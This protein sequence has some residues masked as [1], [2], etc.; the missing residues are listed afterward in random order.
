MM[1]DIL[2][3]GVGWIASG[4]VAFIVYWI[5]GGQQ[6]ICSCPLIPANATPAEIASICHCGAAQPYGLILVG[7]AAI[8][9]GIT[10]L[11]F[12]KKLGR[13]AVRIKKAKY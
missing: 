8:V 2:I 11:I 7:I 4:F 1:R 5:I 6:R 3:T 10:V 9:V 13:I 12:N